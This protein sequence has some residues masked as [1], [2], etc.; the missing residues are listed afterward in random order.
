MSGL[1]DQNQNLCSCVFISNVF[2]DILRMLKKLHFVISVNEFVQVIK[3]TSCSSSCDSSD[4]MK[5]IRLTG[6]SYQ[7]TFFTVVVF[8]LNSRKL[9]F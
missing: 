6:S 2:V 1:S 7:K 4:A 3:I 9:I 5:R 8:P